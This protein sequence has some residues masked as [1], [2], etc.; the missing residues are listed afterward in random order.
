MCGISGII[1]L[2]GFELQ[3]IVA[4]TDNVSHRGPDDEGFVVFEDIKKLPVCFGGQTTPKD[5]YSSNFLY[6]PVDDVKNHQRL[7]AQIS[8]GHRRLSILDLSPAGHQPMSYSNGRFWI[9][10][11]GEIYNYIEIKN[12]LISLGYQFVSNTDTE[13]VLAASLHWGVDCQHKFNGMWAFAIYDCEKQEI[14][15]SRDRFGIKPLYYW[16]APDDSFC[17]ASEIKQ[18]TVFPGW[19]AQIKSTKSL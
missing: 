7:K 17:F 18:F 14:F 5:V 19:E 15:M 13:V 12:E 16:F 9:V 10:F 8:L 6:K 11:N 1:N 2:K 4:I 3:N